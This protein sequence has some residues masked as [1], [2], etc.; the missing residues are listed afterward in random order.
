[1]TATPHEAQVFPELL[2]FLDENGLRYEV[3]DGCVVVTPPATF[4][5]ERLDIA[6][7]AQLWNAAP[8][9]V[10]V[11]G[12]NFGYYYDDTSFVMADVTVA[13]TAD[14]EERG[15]TVAPLLVVEVLSRS[16]RRR[17]VTGKWSIYAE[18]GV[19]SYWLVDPVEPSLTVLTLTDGLYVETERVAGSEPLTVTVPFEVTVRLQR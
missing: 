17:D 3:L 19:P 6:I 7:A 8:E 10:E 15:T 11:L 2:A 16:T 12:S 5:H 14:C 9:G 1:M 4:G 18:A 13:R